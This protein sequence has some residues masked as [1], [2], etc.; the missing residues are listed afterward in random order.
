MHKYNGFIVTRAD[1]S[2]TYYTIINRQFNRRPYA[3]YIDGAQ[4]AWMNTYINRGSLVNAVKKL[5]AE[6]KY[7]CPNVIISEAYGEEL[8]KK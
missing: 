3:L 8:V 1:G 4:C 5:A 2:R 6:L 7:N